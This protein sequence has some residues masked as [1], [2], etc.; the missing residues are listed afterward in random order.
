MISILDEDSMSPI[1]YN[2]LRDDTI[3]LDETAYPE[4]DR[5]NIY[6]LEDIRL[7]EYNNQLRFIAT[8]RNYA[9]VFKNRMVIGDYN[10]E[11][12]SYDNC[13]IIES[14]QNSQYEKNWIPI[15]Y[16]GEECFIYSWFPMDIYRVNLETNTLVPVCRHLDTIIAPNFYR[17][18]G[19]TTFVEFG[20]VLIGVVH[21]SEETVPRQYYHMLVS[22]EKILI[23]L[24]VIRK[25]FT[26]NILA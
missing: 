2:I 9:P 26:F 12:L 8:N 24:F 1:S 21:F 15:C 11:N 23:I 20:D 6:G 13:Q 5:C 16:N 17:V 18:R 3:E 19:S 10:I 22:L 25:R 7:Y 4:S 14:P